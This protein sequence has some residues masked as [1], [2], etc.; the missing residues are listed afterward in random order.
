M[1]ELAEMMIEM[2]NMKGKFEP[3]S[4]FLKAHEPIRVCADSSKAEKLLGWGERLPPRETIQRYI[5]WESEVF[6]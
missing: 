6:S 5:L 1:R 4:G 2:L 3:V